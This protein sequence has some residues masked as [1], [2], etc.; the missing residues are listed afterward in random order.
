MAGDLF[1][2]WYH[3]AKIA[4]EVAKTKHKQEE[5]SKKF[6]LLEKVTTFALHTAG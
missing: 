2:E 5:I 1:Q 6:V 3:S 4:N